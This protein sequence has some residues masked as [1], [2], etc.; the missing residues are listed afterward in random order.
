MQSHKSNLVCPTKKQCSHPKE[1]SFSPATI[2]VA[3]RALDEFEKRSDE[4][5]LI[6]AEMDR[7]LSAL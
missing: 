6:R 4:G 1:S 3:K 7:K 5:F 2:E